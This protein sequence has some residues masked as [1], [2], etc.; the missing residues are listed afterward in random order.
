[1]KNLVVNDRAKS[2]SLGQVASPSATQLL[3][4]KQQ[5][6]MQS[7]KSA[8]DVNPQP[9]VP[10]VRSAAV[11]QAEHE[12]LHAK[13]WL[14]LYLLKKFGID[15]LNMDANIKLLSPTYAEEQQEELFTLVKQVLRSNPL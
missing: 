8:T 9:P 6:S 4:L 1:M 3:Q 14:T 15:Q 5:H 12:R 2:V 13:L 10:K 11:L 7:Q